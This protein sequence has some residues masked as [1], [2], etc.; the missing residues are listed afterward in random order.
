MMHDT[1]NF[2][3]IQKNSLLNLF[4]REIERLSREY[5]GQNLTSFNEG[6]YAAYYAILMGLRK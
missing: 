4:E 3:D 1:R 5:R 6:L 2:N